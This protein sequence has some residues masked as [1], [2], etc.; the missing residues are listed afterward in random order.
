[1][2]VTIDYSQTEESIDISL[3]GF[4]SFTTNLSSRNI[5]SKKCS[6]ISKPSGKKNSS[7]TKGL[8]PQYK[9]NVS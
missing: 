2:I 6:K 9:K 8:V 1:M 7:E 3:R 4:N 5:E